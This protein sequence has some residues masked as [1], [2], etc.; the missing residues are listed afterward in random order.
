MSFSSLEQFYN[1]YRI[2]NEQQPNETTLNRPS[3]RLK[4]EVRELK[5]VL[6]IIT[7]T[8]I[9]TW[10]A[11]RFYEK[12]EYVNF[13]GLPYIS[14]SDDNIDKEPVSHEDYW[15]LV[16]LPIINQPKYLNAVD[17]YSTNGTDYIFEV[18]H[19]LVSEPLVFIDGILQGSDT[20]TYSSRYVTF[21]NTPSAGHKITILYGYQYINSFELPKR[22]FT[23]SQDQVI[24][25]VPF[26]LNNPCVFVNGVLMPRNLYKFSANL[27]EM[28]F[29]LNE[30][31][32]VTISNGVTMGYETYSKDEMDEKFTHFLTTDNAYT[33]S[34]MN[35]LLANKLEI[36]DAEYN[37]AK[38]ENVYRKEETQ[39]LLANLD[40]SLKEEIQKNIADLVHKGSSLADYGILDAYTKDETP[41]IV[42]S[43]LTASLNSGELKNALD[44]KANVATSIAGYG[45]KDAYTSAEIDGLLNKKVDSDQFT[46]NNIYNL[47]SDNFSNFLRNNAFEEQVGG[48]DFITSDYDEDDKTSVAVNT[49]DVLNKDVPSIEIQTSKGTDVD[50]SAHYRV[51]SDL[52]TDDLVVKVEGEF[53]GYWAFKMSQIGVVD[54]TKYNW[55][56]EVIPTMT[57]DNLDFVPKGYGSTFT[58]GSTKTTSASQ[59]MYNYGWLDASQSTV[60]LVSTCQC[61]T[62]VKETYAHYVLTGYDKRISQRR[63]FNQG[64]ADISSILPKSD[65]AYQNEYAEEYIKTSGSADV[66]SESSNALNKLVTDTSAVAQSYTAGGE[67]YTSHLK[68]Y[69]DTYKIQASS[70]FTIWVI[71]ANIGDTLDITL[72]N[73]LSS[74]DTLSNI[75]VDDTAAISFNITVSERVTTG[76]KLTITAK[77]SNSDSV[78][79]HFMAV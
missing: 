74:A 40:E 1:N 52:N 48:I 9:E 32:I 56:I 72:P 37:Y 34:E 54:Y 38:Y 26:T 64:D 53:K 57:G 68:I 46:A 24:F 10:T 11:A 58:F 18:S 41:D 30:G 67:N 25:H 45:I 39:E 21:N 23:A 31:D 55:F 15:K 6:D 28:N 65:V 51:H 61:D 17:E 62:T 50:T 27:I 2:K 35:V 76:V 3:M 29:Y 66:P 63:T 13:N 77:S 42:N 20:F 16:D 5:S 8:E 43:L 7:G 73:G 79:C 75:P 22:E 12:D 71:G 19:S 36:A 60:Y 69:A 78:E 33:K 14:L 49:P 70:T 44:L 4:R 47:I 59:S